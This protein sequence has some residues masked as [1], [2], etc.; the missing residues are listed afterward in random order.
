MSPENWPKPDTHCWDEDEERDVWSYSKDQVWEIVKMEVEAAKGL[1]QATAEALDDTLED[2]VTVLNGLLPNA[3]WKRF[4]L[5]I[6]GQRLTIEKAQETL[7]ADRKWLK[8][9]ADDSK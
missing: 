6:A 2:S 1:M 3:G 5:Q 7:T 8:E 4:D 9:T